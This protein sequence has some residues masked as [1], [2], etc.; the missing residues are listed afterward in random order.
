MP[1]L[2]APSEG[3]PLGRIELPSIGVDKTVVFGVGRD[4][5]RSGPGNYPS[6][7]LPGEMGNVAI[8]GHRTTH[9]APFGDLDQLAPGDEI[10]LDTPAGRLTYRVQGHEAGDG[11][12][13]GHRIV[14]PSEVGVIGDHG[15]DRLTLT[16]CHPKYSARQRIVVSAL[17][18][19]NPADP[20]LDAPV[21]TPVDTQPFGEPSSPAA[22]S[23]ASGGTAAGRVAAAEAGVDR[24]V[25]PRVMGFEDS[26]GWQASE[27]EPTLLWATV[28]ALT[29]F[30][31]WV[32]ARFLPGRLVYPALAPVAGVPLFLFY[33]HLERLLPAY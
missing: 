32:I 6:S 5:L 23:L 14:S 33:L 4:T 24:A 30:S 1:G 12:L 11:G 15:D 9:G 27:A 7:A 17:L 19:T 16:A 8:A 31:L 13:L 21:D 18:V 22:A 10:H 2:P 20:P 26:L 3:D 25:A 28:T 29:L